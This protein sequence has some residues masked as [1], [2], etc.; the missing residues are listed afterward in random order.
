MG[1]C[2]SHLTASIALGRDQEMTMTFRKNLTAIIAALAL[3]F[4]FASIGVAET[5]GDQ[6]AFDRG[7]KAYRLGD[8]AGA[9]AE[10]QAAAASGHVGAAWLLGNL[11]DKGIGGATR[12]ASKAYEYYLQAARGGQPEAAVRIGEIYLSGNEEI[13]V[14]RN[15]GQAL[16]SF[17][18]A[19]LAARGDAQYYVGLMHRNGWGTQIN[20]T[21]GMRWLILSSQKRYA[22]A[23]AELGRIHMEGDGL[24]QDRV[25]GWSY[26]MLSNRYG[27][28]EQR[29]E[30]DKL[31]SKYD[32]WMRRGEKEKASTLAE[33]WVSIHGQ[34]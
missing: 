4:V 28:P 13:G 8:G 31:M 29:Q 11:Y 25:E 10:W 16:K 15:Y 30:T 3:P 20:R 19:A 9:I 18:V 2:A 22:P 24:D 7:L 32:G 5:A 34:K 14:K 33:T 27:T 6:A 12:S 23:L 26:L 21:E 1:G 17:E